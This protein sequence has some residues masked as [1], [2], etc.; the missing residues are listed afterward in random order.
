MNDVLNILRLVPWV[1]FILIVATTAFNG[2]RDLKVIQEYKHLKRHG[3]WVTG[4]VSDRRDNLSTSGF[5]QWCVV[6]Y[7]D[8]SGRAHEVRSL[9]GSFALPDLAASTWVV[10]DPCLPAEGRIGI[11]MEQFARRRLAIIA[12][13]AALAAVA[14]I[15]GIALEV[16]LFL[17]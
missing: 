13:M 7:A 5:I 6:Q 9:S 3:V 1:F 8:P 16:A 14:A 11:D 10:Y 2:Y 12:A 17:R 4:I 15:A